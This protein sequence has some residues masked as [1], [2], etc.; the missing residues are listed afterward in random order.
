[1][2]NYST[3]YRFELPLTGER[4]GTWGDMMNTFMGTL[5][6][7]ALSGGSSIVIPTDA[8]YT[9]V[10]AS[11]ASDETRRLILNVTSG[12]ALSAT[13][14][15]II[16]SVR[17]VYSV[18]NNTTGGQSIRI[19]TASSTTIV[20]IPNGRRRFVFCDGTNTFDMMSDLPSGATA[21]GVQ[22]VTL[23]ASQSL[24]NKTLT[25]PVITTPTI[26]VRDDVLTIQDNLDN[27]KQ[28]RL[29][30]SSISP[31]Q[32]RIVTLPD[33]NIT[34]V[35]TDTT[36]TLTNKTMS[37]LDT[38][39]T[40]QDNAA[41]TKQAVFELSQITAG[42]TR[43]I[44]VPDADIALS[45]SVVGQI[46]GAYTVLATDRSDTLLFNSGSNFTVTLPVFPNGFYFFG[47][48]IGA[49]TVTITPASGTIAGGSSLVLRTG[50]WAVVVSGGTNHEALHT[51]RIV[52]AASA[53]EVGTRGI[54]VTT[55]DASYQFAL[56]DEGGIIRHSSASAHT[57]TIPA[58]GSVAFP[59]GTA[60]TIV[61]EPGAG[62]VTLAITSDT[63]NRGDGVAGTGSRTIGP[64]SL[65]T[66]IKTA[67]TTWVVTG[68][69]T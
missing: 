43:S 29:E 14:D 27:T 20:T 60:I 44:T 33:A 30:L 54:P 28:A 65:V 68:A 41:P 23:S 50:E 40:L 17:K 24:S 63:L 25:S 5:L 16:P 64:N 9:L 6:E 32:T 11:G 46:T 31:G 10:T 39:F 67:A 59:V 2:P 15:I 8:N 37:F 47:K 26:T 58:N 66:V 48:N 1:M 13:R 3:S 53:R 57:Y 4:S 34:L 19:R 61:N 38:Q 51:G 21:D 69:F 18:F 12:I 52:G 36:Q 55:Q 42:T 62:A 49:G 35:G 56:G 22:L 7:D 45:A